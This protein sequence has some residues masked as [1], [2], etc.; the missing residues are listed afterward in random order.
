M[1]MIKEIC[2]E[3]GES[4]KF[5][6]K[7]RKYLNRVFDF[8]DYECR[9]NEMKKPFPEGEFICYECDRKIRELE[10]VRN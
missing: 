5:G 2:N 4:V 6:E 10:Y 9:R 7:S 8:N 1:N 3:C